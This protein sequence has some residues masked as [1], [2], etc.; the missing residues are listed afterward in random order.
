M[1]VP[2]A[3]EFAEI[4]FLLS[5]VPGNPNNFPK[6]QSLRESLVFTFAMNVFGL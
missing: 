4:S 3:K 6:Y 2:V 1:L 5:S